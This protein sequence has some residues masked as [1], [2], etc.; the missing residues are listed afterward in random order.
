MAGDRRQTRATED[1]SNGPVVSAR[2][3]KMLYMIIEHFHDGAAPEVYKRFRD[4][5]RMMPEGLNYVAS[6]IEPNFTRCFQVMEW[7]DRALFDEWASKWDRPDGFRSCACSHI[8]RGAGGNARRCVR[9][10]QSI[11]SDNA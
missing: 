11:N 3:I 1:V 4:Q 5:G 8:G 2:R 6:W 9:L 7:E 10:A